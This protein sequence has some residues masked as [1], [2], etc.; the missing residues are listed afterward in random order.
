MK[1]TV[2]LDCNGLFFT[3]KEKFLHRFCRDFDVP[4]EVFMP[5]HLEIMN[6]VRRPDAPNIFSLWQPHFLEWGISL[7]EEEFYQYWFDAEKEHDEMIE[8]VKV[9]R[10]TG[11]R[12]IILSNN[13]R[14]RYEYK[15]DFFDKINQSVDAVYYSWNTGFVKPH[16][17]SF[18]LVLATQNVTADQCLFF[19]DSPQNVAAAEGLGITSYIFTN[20][21]E[22]KGILAE[23]DLCQG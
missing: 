12:V 20:I 11:A 19:D 22:M 14:E 5:V 13:F 18:N 6:N 8:C 21:D 1:N 3:L 7:Q 15:K 17:D 9:I 23:Y 16:A 10:A 2:I 4:L